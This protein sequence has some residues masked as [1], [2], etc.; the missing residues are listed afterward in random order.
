MFIRVPK[1]G[2][3]ATVQ[4]FEKLQ[5]INSMKDF[6]RKMVIEYKYDID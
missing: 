1:K 4:I 2:L 3:S 6:N 5:K